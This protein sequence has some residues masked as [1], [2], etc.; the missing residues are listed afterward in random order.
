MRRKG[1]ISS[2]AVAVVFSA[3][4]CLLDSAK[5]HPMKYRIGQFVESDITARIPFRVLQTD[6]L[7]QAADD[8][9]SRAPATFQLED[10]TFENLL[11]ALEKMPTRLADAKLLKD[12]PAA[13]AKPLGLTP[14]TTEITAAK[15]ASDIAAKL[16]TDEEKQAEA[17]TA[18]TQADALQAKVDAIVAAQQRIYDG[19]VGLSSDTARGG[20]AA[21]L[22]A[23]REA[24][25][26]CY[27]VTP[28]QY[29][30]Q[31]GRKAIQVRMVV[32]GGDILPDV[33][34]LIGQD[35]D[36][37]MRD[38]LRR[39]LL[40][41][42]RT[43]RESLE[44]YLVDTLRAN[45]LY[46][47]NG[48][49]SS[50]DAQAAAAN[51]RANPPESVYRHYGAGQV[52]IQRTLGD[53][54]EEADS[55][56][57]SADAHALLLAE[58]DAYYRMREAEELWPLRAQ[59]LSRIG[60]L[61]LL[62]SLLCAYI[63]IYHSYLLNTLVD[64]IRL[65]ALLAV[66]LGIQKLL[67]FSESTNAHAVLL[68]VCLAG[69][70]MAIAY[71]RRFSL[72]VGSML[73]AIVVFEMRGDFSMLLV[74]LAGLTGCVLPLR[75]IRTRSKVMLVAMG[76]A[77]GTMLVVWAMGMSNSEPWPIMLRDSL[78]SAGSVVLA[79]L[80]VQALL[81]AIERLF[82]VVTGSTLLEWCDA[83]KALLKRLAMEVPGTYNH[84]LQLGVMCEAAADAIGAR[85]LLARV[86]AYYHDIGKTNK[87]LYFIENQSG[88]V[89]PHDKLSPAMS[90][91]VIVDHVKEGLKIA[92]EYGLPPVLWEFIGT[93][94]GT[95]LVSFFYHN[96]VQA[97][98][99]AGES[100]P[101]ESGFRYPGPKPRSAE[102]AILALADGAESSVR[103]MSDPT[104][105]RIR[106]QV[107][108]ILTARLED[109]QLDEC[110][111]TLA[112]VHTIGESLVK[113]LCGAYH[114]R[115]AYPSEKKE[116]PKPPPADAN[117]S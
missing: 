100:L 64:P 55:L 78:W 68:P 115:I 77:G 28:D 117:D 41:F 103:A 42:P 87:P 16:A 47:Y 72:T 79:A 59:R 26:R 61:L 85:G 8:E 39:A 17:A 74:L 108:A 48:K 58:R 36:Q 34:D 9:I 113:S 44:A 81:P 65:A 93:H 53:E 91:L 102:A 66:C 98:T 13:L 71:D 60:I 83:S 52:L 92:R 49:K 70:V 19:W 30:A 95:T 35:Q 63:A 20:Y 99:E 101:D 89:N 97:A 23:L 14:P 112:D 109:G 69:L 1:T 4:V 27:V 96:A 56:G 43:T 46:V 88:G 21:N 10:T 114:G 6:K 86:G 3:V 80:I 67:M 62:V 18:K 105:T 116:E 45:P 12:V 11:T 104:P 29:A 84:S 38:R 54:E 57:L 50:E 7:A 94:H 24:L 15:E 51:V 37:K 76:A 40:R 2:L 75:E 31:V 110:S 32:D 106:T 5:P 111:L 82:N 22:A 90:V 25:L 107:H 73:A 33:G